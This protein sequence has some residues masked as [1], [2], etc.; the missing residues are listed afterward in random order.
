MLRFFL[1][2]FCFVV[3]SSIYALSP[4]VSYQEMARDLSS[5]IASKTSIDTLSWT[6]PTYVAFSQKYLHDLGWFSEKYLTPYHVLALRP[7]IDRTL[8]YRFHIQQYPLSCEIAALQ[9]ILWSLRIRVSED[10]IFSHIPQYPAVYD[11]GGIWWDPNIQFV[12]SYTGWQAKQTGYGVYEEP[13][14]QYAKNHKLKTEIINQ[15]SY[16][17][18]MNS[19]SHLTLLL[20]NLSKR[21]AHMLLWWD[22]C[23]DPLYEDG[24][25]SK[26]GK[27]ISEFFPLSG[28]NHC[29]RFAESRI[30]KW[31]TPDGKE[32]NWLSGEHAFILLGYVGKIEKPSHIIVWDTYTGRHIYPYAEWM[33]KWWRMEYRS[34]IISR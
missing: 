16:S 33:R 23:T 26:W 34:L 6:G 18:S 8:A 11:T 15:E 17:G 5:L 2:L 9:I 27:W 22:W 29:D 28:R 10:D 31:I 32:I 13:L 19:G 25:L 24:I 12:W 14:A 30:M 21:N 20:R 7:T 4:K 1:F 3:S